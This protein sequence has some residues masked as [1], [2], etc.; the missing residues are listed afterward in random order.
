MPVDMQEAILV[1]ETGFSPD[2]LDTFPQAT[3]ERI[4]LYKEI[5]NITMTGGAFDG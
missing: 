1:V 3:L 5:K 2:Q 4:L